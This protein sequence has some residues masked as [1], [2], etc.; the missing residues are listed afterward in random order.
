MVAV[1]PGVELAQ[2]GAQDPLQ[3]PQPTLEQDHVEASSP[4]RGRHLGPDPAGAH[5]EHP[6]AQ[7]NRSDRASASASVRR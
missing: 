2:L 6:P 3:W 7:A 4:R 5:D 1:H